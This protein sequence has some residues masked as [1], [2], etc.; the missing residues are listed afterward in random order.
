MLSWVEHEKSFITS[1]PVYSLI[2]STKNNYYNNRIT[3]INTSL[4]LSYF[5]KAVVQDYCFDNTINFIRLLVCMWNTEAYVLDP[6]F[7]Y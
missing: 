2:K 4:L 5:I 3:G 1:W 6:A 7:E